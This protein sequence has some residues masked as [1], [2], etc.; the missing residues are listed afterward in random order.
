MA[1]AQQ[2]R[3]TNYAVRITNQRRRD[4]LVSEG[5]IPSAEDVRKARKIRLQRAREHGE[6][7]KGKPN[8]ART[9][10]TG[11]CRYSGKAASLRRSYHPREAHLL[12]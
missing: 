8:I 3:K 1:T 5:K 2:R 7:T 12:K 11:R 9:T 10:Y 6:H 4:K